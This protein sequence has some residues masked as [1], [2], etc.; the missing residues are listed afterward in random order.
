MEAKF[1]KERWAENR[2]GW[3]RDDVNPKLLRWWPQIG[4]AEGCRV[5]V[6]LCGKTLDLLWLQQQGHAV[7]GNDL[8]ELAAAN[9]FTE[10]QLDVEHGRCEP[11]AQLRHG[12]LQ[13][14]VGDFFELQRSHLTGVKAWLDRAA[15]VAL[16]QEL[17]DAYMQH[18][19]DLLPTGAVGLLISFEFQRAEPSGPPFS[20]VED[21][22]MQLCKGRFSCEL[23]ERED[24]MQIP[25]YTEM[26]LTQAAET[27]YRL[28]RTS[29]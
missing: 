22:V 1:W 3:H 10:A 23:L 27:V 8:S 7:I 18:L 11:F 20:V 21:E 28:E 2:I 4:V 17:R 12:E 14:L 26:G 15:L 5:L 29:V 24:L 6:P 19:A 25:R 13:Y 9:F 16:P